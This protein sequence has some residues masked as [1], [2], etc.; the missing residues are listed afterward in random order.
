MY[1]G[2]KPGSEGV[3]DAGLLRLGADVVAVVERDGAL[4]LEVEHRL[5][6]LAHAAARLA[7]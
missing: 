6:V 1:A 4:R 2:T 5:H 3:V 7:M